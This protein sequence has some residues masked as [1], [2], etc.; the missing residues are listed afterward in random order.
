[1]DAVGLQSNLMMI[2]LVQG[3]RPVNPENFLDAAEECSNHLGKVMA[4]LAVRC[5]TLPAV[6]EPPEEDTN[7]P[8]R[9]P[10]QPAP[11]ELLVHLCAALPWQDQPSQAVRRPA[12]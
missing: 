3:H 8:S 11:D 6:V 9:R 12:V 5:R 7:I 1:M 2:C 4:I 10:S